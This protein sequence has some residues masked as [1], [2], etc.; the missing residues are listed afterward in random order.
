[1]AYLDEVTQGVS[2]VHRT[3]SGVAD[4]V[5]HGTDEKR[6]QQQTELDVVFNSSSYQLAKGILPTSGRAWGREHSI[7]PRK[8]FLSIINKMAL[9]K[10]EDVQHGTL[11]LL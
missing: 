1:M 2:H 11:L 7:E 3:H 9:R 4:D 8:D 10:D 6:R 5:D